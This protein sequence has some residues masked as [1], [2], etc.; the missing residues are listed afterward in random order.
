LSPEIIEGDREADLSF[1]AARRDFGGAGGP[2]AV[3]DVGGGSTEL[4]FG[5]GANPS[6]HVSLQVGSVRL[7]ERLVHDDPPSHPERLAVRATVD[8]ALAAVPPPPAGA[9]LIGVAGTLTTLATLAQ[10]LPAYDAGRVHGAELSLA[11]ISTLANRLWSLPMEAR[12]RLPGLQPGRADVIPVGALIVET[13]LYRLR[14]D[15]ITVSDRGIR[16][17]LLYELAADAGAGG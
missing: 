9:R 6:F 10:G 12:R 2:L 15:R 14:L 13:V 1:L 17:G 11:E 8:A 4:V 3:L 5:A 7:F 16:W